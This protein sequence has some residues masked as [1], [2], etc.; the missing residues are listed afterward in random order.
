MPCHS[1][2]LLGTPG[3]VIPRRRLTVYNLR[4]PVRMAICGLWLTIDSLRLGLSIC[5]LLTIDGH[6]LALDGNNRHLTGHMVQTGKDKESR[7]TEEKAET[8]KYKK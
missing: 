8:W 3:H 7:G 1:R 2:C 4:L 5:G 6:P